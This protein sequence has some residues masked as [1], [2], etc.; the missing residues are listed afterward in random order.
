MCDTDVA[1][2]TMDGEA[3][4]WDVARSSLRVSADP[5]LALALTVGMDHAV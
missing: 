1:V 2:V 5:K 4:Y 3:D